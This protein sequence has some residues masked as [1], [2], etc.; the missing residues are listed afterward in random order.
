MT[1]FSSIPPK[2]LSALGAGMLLSLI[3]GTLY[4]WSV[5]VLPLEELTGWT[6]AQ[7]S[8]TF[9]LVILFFSIGMVSGGFLLARLGPR[10][11]ALL[12]GAMLAAGL[13]GAAH[14]S[15]LWHLYLAYGVVAGYGIGMANIVPSAV[16]LRWFPRH[17]GLICG[18]LALCLAAGTFLFGSIVA[19]HLIA[20]SGLRHALRA[21]SLIV[22]LC[23]G[24]AARFLRYPPATAAMEEQGPQV[25]PRAMLL[26]PKFRSIWLWALGIQ[27]GGL[28]IA[29]HLVPYAVEN[30][31]AAESAAL[32]VGIYALGNGAG[33][34]VFGWLF[35][36]AGVRPALYAT[37]TTALFGVMGLA[38]LPGAAGLFAS[39][40]CA[41]AAYGG[42]VPLF[43]ALIVRFFGTRWLHTNIGFSTTS[44]MVASLIGPTL[45]SQA[46][47]LTGVYTAAVWAAVTAT[48]AAF[49]GASLLFRAKD[50]RR[51]A[52]TSGT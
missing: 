17:S 1:P 2:A 10:L 6:R 51:P 18:I 25:S 43:S 32:S 39:V 47:R 35:D 11:T 21:L 40:L 12:G 50:A 41:A 15:D 9:T 23:V 44:L 27:I 7:T 28:M 49:A 38:L 30:G 46:H 16:C 24:T 36:K 33:R 52:P 5:F 14:A 26:D 34:L 48:L 20:S 8:F 29:G 4:A 19:T 22:L 3:N 45:G 13:T 37:A 42:T 31:V